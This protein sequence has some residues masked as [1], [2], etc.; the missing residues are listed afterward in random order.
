M[1]VMIFWHSVEKQR[2][3]CRS[4]KSAVSLNWREFSRVCLYCSWESFGGGGRGALTL[5]LK[6]TAVY[7]INKKTP[8]LHMQTTTL[9]SSASKSNTTEL[10]IY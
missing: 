6:S 1:M 9:H 7:T 3:T 10:T 4:G 2:V 5:A 8:L